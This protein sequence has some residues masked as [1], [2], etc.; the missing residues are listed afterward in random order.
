MS[1]FSIRNIGK[2]L[3]QLTLL[4]ATRTTSSDAAGVYPTSAYLAATY[5]QSGYADVTFAK[6]S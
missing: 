4:D 6:S 3:A 5:V 1:L 2:R